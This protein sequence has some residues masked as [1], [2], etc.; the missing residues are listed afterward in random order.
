MRKIILIII[1]LLTIDSLSAQTL[2]DTRS[3]MICIAAEHPPKPNLTDNELEK[4]LN[5]FIDP[6]LLESYKADYLYITF[7]VNCKGE[8]FDYKLAKRQDGKA[9]KDSLS[10]FQEVFLTKM[11]SLLTWSPATIEI[12]EKG[13]QIE[14]AVDFQGSYTIHFDGSKFHILNEK[15]K[16]KHFEQKLKK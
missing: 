16:K 12:K 7:L 10:N 11:Q 6:S 1:A 14:K 13:K 3:G 4:E 15:E 2:C 5:S 8:D 9:Q